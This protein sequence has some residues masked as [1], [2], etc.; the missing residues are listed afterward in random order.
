VR[1]ASKL[2]KWD[3]DIVTVSEADIEKLRKEGIPQGEAGKTTAAGTG[4][5]AK[6]IPPADGTP[7][8]AGAD[9]ADGAGPAAET[10]P[11]GG[12]PTSEPASL[13]GKPESTEEASP[14]A[15]AAE[16][17][18]EKVTGDDPKSGETDEESLPGTQAPAIEESPKSESAAD[19]PMEE[20]STAPPASGSHP[21]GESSPDEGP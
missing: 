19:A 16:V 6:A 15:S 2:S 10:E 9:S 3:L 21:E 8:A 13:E 5:S 4:D 17:S 1:L 18:G 12:T 14:P 20:A 7:L 11:G